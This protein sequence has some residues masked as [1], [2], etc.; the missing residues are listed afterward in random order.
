M[1]NEWSAILAKKKTTHTALSSVRQTTHTHAH[2]YTHFD[3]LRC[4]SSIDYGQLL[5]YRA[6][7]VFYF[8]LANDV[9]HR[10]HMTAIAQC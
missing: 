4:S 8:N 6:A 3:M 9:S 5:R 7:F 10:A 2:A 1:E